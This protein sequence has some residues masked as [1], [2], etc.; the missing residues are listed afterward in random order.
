[1]V[2]LKKG[3]QPQGEEIPEEAPLAK[4]GFR[5]GGRNCDPLPERTVTH[6]GESRKIQEGNA[7]HTEGYK[8]DGSSFLPSSP[9]LPSMTYQ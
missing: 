4:P 6:S 9:A 7:V 1:M 2:W 5:V 3:M 8:N